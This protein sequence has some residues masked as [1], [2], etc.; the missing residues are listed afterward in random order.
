MAKFLV[1]SGNPLSGEVQISGAKNAVLPL[2]ASAILSKEKCKISDVPNLIDVKVMRDILTYLGGSVKP[3]GENTLEINMDGLCKQEANYEYTSKMRASF[4][5]MGPLLA[6][7]GYAKV[8]MPG[9]CTIGERP[10]DLHLKGFE[11]L[12]AEIIA[13]ENYIEAKACAGGLKGAT[14]YLDFPSVGA[15]ENIMMAAVLARGITYIENVA[16]EP[17][18]VDL[19][20]FMN[21][22]GAKIK[23]AG[24]DTIKIEGVKSL[25]GASHNV[26]PDRIETATFMLAAAITRGEI[27]IKNIVP[28]HVKPITAKLRECGV[29]IEISDAGLYVNARDKKLVATAIKTLPY[30]GFPTDIQSPFMSFLTT[31]E[32]ASTVIETVFENR[33]MHVAEL[34]RMGANIKTDGNKANIQ[35]GKQLEGARVIATDLRAG[36]AM[37]LA[38]LVASGTTEV[39]DIY[40][41]ERGY[42]KFVEKFRKL[43]ANIL[44][45]ED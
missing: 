21:K 5:L 42:E 14:I 30:P 23:G 45:I 4:L 38:G 35:G 24:T 8:Y 10:I 32:G 11:A 26:I 19:A 13:K 9:G 1:Q 40:H 18:I 27:L 15:T 31:V 22:M 20:N 37:V 7:D 17:E 34:N 3:I 2:M 39:A 29:E 43:G 33:F 36:A 16:Q 44:R 41:I 12:G 28:D 25:H 6:R